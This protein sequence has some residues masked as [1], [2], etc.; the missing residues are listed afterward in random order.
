MY[1]TRKNNTLN[2]SDNIADALAMTNPTSTGIVKINDKT[3]N[4]FSTLAWESARHA[5]RLAAKQE[6]ARIE[7]PIVAG[8][9]GA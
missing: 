6:H 3:M 4:W 1:I 5:L 8:T 2:I 9:F 7:F